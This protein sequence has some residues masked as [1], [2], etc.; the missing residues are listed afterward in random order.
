MRYQP[1]HALSALAAC[2][3]TL[4]LIAASSPPT[5]PFATSIVGILA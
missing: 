3:A 1:Y 4:V 2:V 5:A